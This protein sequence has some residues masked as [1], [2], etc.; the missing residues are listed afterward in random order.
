MGQVLARATLWLFVILLGIDI[1]AGTYEARNVV[2]LWASGAPAS[3]QADNPYTRVA[4]DA[5]LNWWRYLTPT[6]AVVT[7]AALLLSGAAPAAGRT[8]RMAA[9]AL[10]L[11]VIATT[12]TYFIPGIMLMLVRH[13]DGQPP[14]VLAAKASLWASVNWVRV[15]VSLAAWVA[16]LRALTLAG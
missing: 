1:G 8:W 13:G 6:L 2:P 7:L 11:L 12:V 16:G 14:G 3:L 5:G 4:T 15:V 9:T 10:E